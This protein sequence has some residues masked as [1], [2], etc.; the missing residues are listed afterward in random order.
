MKTD[1]QT[2]IGEQPL[3][4]LGHAIYDMLESMH[5]KTGKPWAEILDDAKKLCNWVDA[6]HPST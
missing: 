4:P 1:E 2:S 5:R 3:S 6:Q